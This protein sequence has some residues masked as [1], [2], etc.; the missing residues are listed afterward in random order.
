MKY[1]LLGAVIV[2]GAG[3]FAFIR[4]LI[5]AMS[6]D[7][8]PDSAVIVTRP[9]PPLVSLESREYKNLLFNFSLV[10]PQNLT[11]RE[12]DDGTSASTITFGERTWKGFQIYIVPY[13]YEH[14][15]QEQLK[16][17]IPSGVII[18][19]TDI[20]IDGVKSTV[21]FS[22][23]SVLGDTREVWF[24]RNAFLYEVTTRRELDS[25]LADIMKTWRFNSYTAR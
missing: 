19:P 13:S 24:I 25:W 15:T 5:P 17:D 16:K 21:F 20:I 3:A 9:L 18:E 4:F 6:E 14:I 22:K 10:Y 23:D 12:Y 1:A 8:P 2:I 7:I 11:V